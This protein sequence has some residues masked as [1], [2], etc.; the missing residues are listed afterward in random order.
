EDAYMSRK[1]RRLGR[2]AILSPAMKTSPRRFVD[3]GVIRQFASD[4]FL[5]TCDMLGERPHATWRRYNNVNRAAN[6][7]VD[8]ASVA[9]R[10]SPTRPPDLVTA[11]GG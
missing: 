7:A 3:R 2:T 4:L 9:T 5:I 8:E 1:L 10:G 6:E 11:V